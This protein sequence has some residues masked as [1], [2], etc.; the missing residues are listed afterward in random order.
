MQGLSPV[1]AAGPFPICTEFTF[2]SRSVYFD[3]GVEATPH[4]ISVPEIA[5]MVKWYVLKKRYTAY[6]IMTGRGGTSC[7]NRNQIYICLFCFTLFGI[8]GLGMC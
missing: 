5:G 1:T 7:K 2:R 3:I 8:F 6:G 4:E